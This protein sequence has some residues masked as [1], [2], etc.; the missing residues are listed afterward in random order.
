MLHQRR[1]RSRRRGA[2]RVLTVA[3]A[4]SDLGDRCAGQSENL[5][6]LVGFGGSGAVLL[7]KVSEHMRM[8]GRHVERR[9]LTSRA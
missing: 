9:S 6:G 4:E 8:Y 7:M 1:A 3:C 2:L 5:V